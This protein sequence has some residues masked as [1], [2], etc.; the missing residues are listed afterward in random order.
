MLGVCQADSQDVARD[1]VGD[2]RRR[3]V[4]GVPRQEWSKASDGFNESWYRVA[5]AKALVFKATERIVSNQPW[6]QG[7]Y[8]ANIVAYAIAKTAHDVNARGRAVD[9]QRIWRHQAL[10]PAMEEA[11]ATASEA[12]HEILINPPAGISNVTEWAKQQA[13]WGRACDVV[14]RWPS[15]FLKDLISAEEL[16]DEE[17]YAR[18]AQ[19]ELNGIEAQIAVVQAGPEFWAD[20]LEWGTQ[21]KLLTVTEEGVLRKAANRTGTPPSDKQ[22]SKVIDV[23]HKLRSEGYTG[24]LSLGT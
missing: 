24:E 23:F 22:S 19:R 10:D 2:P 9:F 15:A 6:Y 5:A 18:R 13:C 21:R 11:L 14:L 8:R 4:H 17:R 12:V 1:A 16:R 7:G 3:L 20:V